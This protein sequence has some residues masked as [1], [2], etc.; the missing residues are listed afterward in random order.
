MTHL[1]GPAED[2]Y[3]VRL[4]AA[5]IDEAVEQ[6]TLNRV[7]RLRAAGALATIA[8]VLAISMWSAARGLAYICLLA[9]LGLAAYA[10]V[11]ASVRYQ[12]PWCTKARYADVT[13]RCACG[14]LRSEDGTWHASVEAPELFD[15][16]TT[17]PTAWWRLTTAQE[18]RAR[19]AVA[20]TRRDKAA[21]IYPVVTGFIV[22]PLAATL[23][24][25][26]DSPSLIPLVSGLVCAPF[27]IVPILLLSSVDPRAMRTCIGCG[28]VLSAAHADCTACAWKCSDQLHGTRAFRLYLQTGTQVPSQ[29]TDRQDGE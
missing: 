9:A 10:A 6:T 7:R 17:E 27:L 18:G 29:M 16:T 21:Q 14:T 13:A 11:R 1:G 23:M 26:I 22:V 15:A 25:G 3:R 28:A 20:A 19:R 4:G 2:A 12:C 24:F 8:V 5:I